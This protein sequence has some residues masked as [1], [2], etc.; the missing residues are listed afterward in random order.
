MTL[1]PALRDQGLVF[2][3]ERS[4]RERQMAAELTEIRLLLVE[5]VGVFRALRGETAETEP[6]Q[7]RPN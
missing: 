3:A 6:E 5:F 7:P 4:V 1:D 2:L